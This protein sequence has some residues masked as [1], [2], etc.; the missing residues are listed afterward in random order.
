MVDLQHSNALC[1]ICR[2]S[3]PKW[4]C[5]C[6][7]EALCPDRAC[8]G[9]HFSQPSPTHMLVP[10]AA[11]FVISEQEW[12]TCLKVTDSAV[13]A[14][15]YLDE[16]ICRLKQKKEEIDREIDSQVEKYVG[17]MREAAQEAK[18]LLEAE[19]CQAINRVAQL[20]TPEMRAAALAARE[21][22]RHLETI[23]FTFSRPRT[24]A[25]FSISVFPEAT[26][27]LAKSTGGTWEFRGRI[28]AVS[29]LSSKPLY[30]TAL[31][32]SKGRESSSVLTTLEILEGGESRGRVVYKHNQREILISEHP[33]MVTIRLETAVRV[34]ANTAYT[35]KAVAMGGQGYRTGP[36]CLG[37]QEGLVI[38]LQ[39]CKFK[40]ED[41]SNGTVWNSGIFYE[42]C[43]RGAD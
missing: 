9:T 19:M 7:N 23:A 24:D 4:L 17:E 25:I 28:D 22:G 26:Y 12:E 11:G 36:M 5:K 42:L 34:E 15:D 30:L 33:Y 8:V 3:R 18:T 14:S 31:S 10:Y 2:I 21:T 6:A 29:F 43:Y 16:E 13:Q 39:T 37:E 20:R 32:L 1:S 38:T 35:L 40:P 41:Q 27:R